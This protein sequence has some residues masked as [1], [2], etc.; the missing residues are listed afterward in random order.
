MSFRNP[1][2][3]TRERSALPSRAPEVVWVFMRSCRSWDLRL[4]TGRGAGGLCSRAHNFLQEEEEA[5]VL[6]LLLPPPLRGGKNAIIAEAGEMALL[7]S[8]TAPCAPGA[9]PACK[10]R[11]ALAEEA[12]SPVGLRIPLGRRRRKETVVAGS[13]PTR[14]KVLG[15]EV[16]FLSRLPTAG[17]GG[18]ARREG[19]TLEGQPG[20]SSRGGRAWGQAKPC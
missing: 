12:S 20:L 8:S 10:G 6:L 18:L 11:L 4:A 14:A 2:P 15:P 9:G 3:S 7:E 13:C 5:I 17:E 19:K 1:G 16:A